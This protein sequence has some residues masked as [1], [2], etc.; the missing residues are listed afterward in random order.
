[1]S[2]PPANSDHAIDDAGYNGRSDTYMQYLRAKKTMEVKKEAEKFRV[3][4]KVRMSERK[5][6]TL[7][8]Y[9]ATISMISILLAV[10]IQE[11]S[12]YGINSNEYGG[13]WFAQIKT[14]PITASQMTATADKQIV[15][16]MKYVLTK[17]TIVQ[18]FMMV[19]QFRMVTLI[20]IEQKQLDLN[21]QEGMDFDAP[22][23]TL[24]GSFGYSS[25]YLLLLKYGMELAICAIHP[26]PLVKKKFITTIVGRQAIYNVESLVTEKCTST[27]FSA[28]F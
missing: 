7:E 6:L 4:R 26:I 14:P 5:V 15:T 3:G 24:T 13:D 17:L 19:A 11:I 1:M 12:F 10:L 27:H 22:M 23:V 16:L 20:M 21:L 25:S 28:K 9:I 8:K 2:S 18:L